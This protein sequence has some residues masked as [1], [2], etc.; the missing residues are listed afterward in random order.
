[1]LYWIGQGLGLVSTGL[2]IVTPV[3][4]KKW[5]MLA[6]NIC[7]NLILALNLICLDRIGSGIFMFLI[8]AVQGAF[9]LLRTLKNAKPH[10]AENVIFLLL[11]LGLGVYGLVTAPGFVPAVNGQNLLELLPIIGAVLSMCF[12]TTRDEKKARAFYIVCCSVWVV[13]YA[14][15]LSTAI[16]GSLL[17]VI[18]G[19]LAAIRDRKEKTAA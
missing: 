13:Y 15:I 5:Q 2:G 16:F 10:P 12:L 19:I 18:T 1:M 7:G 17:S 4:K 3:F 6:V 8:A 11:Y 14:F 9:N